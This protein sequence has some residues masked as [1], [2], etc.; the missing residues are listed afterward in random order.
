VT[1]DGATSLDVIIPAYNEAERLPGSMTELCRFLAPFLST[2]G[3]SG[4]ITV[5]D[6]G[7]RDA[8]FRVAESFARRGAGLPVRALR[9]DVPGKGAAV[10]HGVL[11]S[12]AT[13][14]GFMDADLATG[15][16]ALTPTL[17]QLAGGVPLVIGTRRHDMSHLLVEHETLRRIGGWAFRAAARSVVPGIADTQCGFK[18]FEGG[19][20]RRLFEQQELT[21]WAFD[22]E[23]LA[24][25][26]ALGLAIGEV[27]V[28]WTNK[29]GSRF[30]PVADGVRA[31]RDIARV[32]ALIRR[33]ARTAVIPAPALHRDN[34]RVR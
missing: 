3:M 26:R 14:V 27:P 12:A 1:T 24:R 28:E 34:T 33:G 31:F 25:A 20:A 13:W 9:C 7:S 8:T 30:D 4:T 32:H 6:N 17:D 18:F 10:R 22:V 21:G 11:A 2:R 29:P 23:V 15:L 5:V 16:A 19:V